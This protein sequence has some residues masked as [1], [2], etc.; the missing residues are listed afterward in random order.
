MTTQLMSDSHPT[1]DPQ[2]QNAVATGVYITI[3]GHFYQPPRENPYLNVI[4][5]QPSAYPFHDWNERILYE[6]Y[7]PNVFSRI[8]NHQGEVVSIVNNFEYTAFTYNTRYTTI[9]ESM[10]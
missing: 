4:E 2:E 6:C 1:Q 9:G 3:H 5:R 8:L 7:R 10:L